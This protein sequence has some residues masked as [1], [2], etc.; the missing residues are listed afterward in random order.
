MTLI[1]SLWSLL[2]TSQSFSLLS[3]YSTKLHWWT[4]VELTLE[5]LFWQPSQHLNPIVWQFLFLRGVDREN[6]PGPVC[7]GK[8]HQYPL[9][10][11]LEDSLGWQHRGGLHTC[12]VWP[13]FGAWACLLFSEELH[14]L[15]PEGGWSQARLWSRPVISA[16]R[17]ISNH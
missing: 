5:P 13:V 10:P 1:S 7:S 3:C 8:F 4:I 17:D 12:L 6:K 11:L 2:E 9:V 14:T 15:G 16:L